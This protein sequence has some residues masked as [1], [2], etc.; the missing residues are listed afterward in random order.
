RAAPAGA[1]DTSR[2]QGVLLAV[3][4]EK[5]GYPAETLNLDM[6]LE[7]DLGIDSIKRVEI[8]AAMREK[9]PEAPPVG[10]QHVGSLRTLRQII[11]FLA[12]APAGGL[13]P[14]G[15]AREENGLR[16]APAVEAAVPAGP[17]IIERSILRSVPFLDGRQA[18]PL[19][20]GREVWVIDDGSAGFQQALAGLAARGFQPKAVQ[21]EGPR[22]EFPER[23]GALILLA[24]R[25]RLDASG[26]WAPGSEEWLKSA[27]QLVR[28]A[29][30]ALRRGTPSLLLTVSRID[31]AFGLED[32]GDADPV[33]GALAGLAKTARAEWPEVRCRAIDLGPG[34]ELGRLWAELDFAGPPEL[35]ITGSGL[36]TLELRREPAR[37]GAAPPSRE[38]NSRA[39]RTARP[40][41]PVLA[42]SDTI[43]ITGGARG[44]TAEAAA[45]L[46][47][48]TRAPIALLGRTPMPGEEPEWLE[49]L[50][51]ESDIKKAVNRASPGLKPKE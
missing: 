19:P 32:P 12:A 36:K 26:L 22:P 4:S 46:A 38:E 49:G 21:L 3:V 11:D 41:A 18:Q 25:A 45:A 9:L 27:F 29:A 35:G 40:R 20:A 50:S 30:P 42:A 5:T 2:V 43:L 23:L 16:A 51:A 13:S 47:L 6:G 39:P 33:F 1:L 10:P 34:A 15:T 37:A 44:V 8:L 24:P 17:R 31:G 28:A 7:S 48:S 14:S